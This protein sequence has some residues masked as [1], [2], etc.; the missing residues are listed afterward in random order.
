[1]QRVTPFLWFNNQAEEAVNYYLSIFEDS[2]ILTKT[3]YGEVGPGPE[4]SIMSIDFELQGQ[5]FVALNGG[6]HFT[7][8]EAVSFVVNCETA[9]EVDHYWEKLSAGGEKSHCG[10]LKDQFGV[11]W[12][13]VPTLLP[14][15]IGDANQEKAQMVMAAMLQMQKL[16][17]V[18]LQTAYDDA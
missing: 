14:R 11:S 6:P 10:W 1:M 15:L 7:F 5:A 13:V 12:Q 8:S 18:A 16:D 17:I 9:E 3:R 4:G 2:R